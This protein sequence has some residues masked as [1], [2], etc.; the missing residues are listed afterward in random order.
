MQAE[1]YGK[2]NSVSE[3]RLTGEFFGALRYLPF[4]VGM[5]NILLHGVFPSSTVQPLQY[6]HQTEWSDKI[7]FWRREDE[8]EPDIVIEL[9]TTVILIEVKY[10]SWLS[11][12]D[13]VDNS[14]YEDKMLYK[15][16]NQQLAREAR[17]LG[18]IANGRTKMLLLLAPMDSA[19]SIW[20]ETIRRDII[21]EPD[22]LFG[23]ITWQAALDALRTLSIH[24]TY[25]QVIIA[26]LSKLLDCKGFG[27]FRGFNAIEPIVN[28]DENWVFDN[29]ANNMKFT[30]NITEAVKENEYYVFK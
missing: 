30:F 18:N 15:R 5:K 28:D 14:E 4:D 27:G 17:I 7:H 21:T 19:H 16:S 24:D 10:N 8:G 22:I 11:S 29:Y 23:Y 2:D 12:D 1:I 25:Q 3:D 26:D 20:S 13:A 6:L 9:D